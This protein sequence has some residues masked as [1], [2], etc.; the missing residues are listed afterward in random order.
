MF[1]QPLRTAGVGQT[2]V[3]NRLHQRV[4]RRTIGPAGP[5]DHIAHHVQVRLQC[6]LLGAKTLDQLNAQGAQLVT[7]RRVDAGVATGDAMPG[8]AGERGQTAHEGAANT[9]NVNVHCPILGGPA[10][11]K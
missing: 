3:Q 11:A 8:F 1:S 2:G 4:F 7:H 10:Q 6:Q 9:Q 5:A